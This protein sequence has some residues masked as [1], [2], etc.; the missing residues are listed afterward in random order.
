LADQPPR[1]I[2]SRL[3]MALKNKTRITRV[4]ILGVSAKY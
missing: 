1:C 3:S 2:I 4:F